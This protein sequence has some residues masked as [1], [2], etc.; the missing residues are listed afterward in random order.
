MREAG[1]FAFEN[2]HKRSKKGL[3][4]IVAL[5]ILF[6][7]VCFLLVLLSRW[8]FWLPGTNMRA[9]IKAD[10]SSVHDLDVYAT[11]LDSDRTNLPYDFYDMPICKPDPFV[12]YNL[13]IGDL[14]FGFRRYDAP[15]RFSSLNNQTIKSF[16][17]YTVSGTQYNFVRSSI[18]EG[19]RMNFLLDNLD[20]FEPRPDGLYKQ[21]FP[22]GFL[23]VTDNSNVY[24]VNN[25]FDIRVFYHILPHEGDGD[26]I[27]HIVGFEAVP[28]SVNW[29]SSNCDIH[30]VQSCGHYSLEKHGEIPYT[31]SV[32]WLPSKLSWVSRWDKYLVRL[33]DGNMTQTI[34]YSTLIVVLLGV[35]AS[36]MFRRVVKKSLLSELEMP[37]IEDRDTLDEILE[38]NGWKLIATNVYRTPRFSGLLSLFVGL[39]DM[40]LW[41]TIVLI[42]C[43]WVGLFSPARRNAVGTVLM[44]S[45]ILLW[46]RCS[47]VTSRKLREFKNKKSYRS[48]FLWV[49]IFI[50]LG[51]LAYYI[52]IWLVVQQSDTSYAMPFLA[53]IQY[54]LVFFVF[55]SLTAVIGIFMSKN[56]K[57]KPP[58]IVPDALPREIP[59]TGFPGTYSLSLIVSTLPF[60]S[61]ALGIKFVFFSITSN[62]VVYIF[63]LI[64]VI[65]L[66]S[67]IV[68]ILTSTITCYI[69]LQREDY[70][71]QWTS[72]FDSF[73]AGMY[74]FLYLLYEINSLDSS[75]VATFLMIHW[76][77]LGCLC[78]G[79]AFGVTGYYSA[80]IFVNRLYKNVKAH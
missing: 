62:H 21:G 12:S 10:N 35:V 56:S 63:G 7:L 46:V 11:I 65:F 59:R 22:I 2:R 80:R 23:G 6:V 43:A 42:A 68:C 17:N 18:I 50:P 73:F 76:G 71:W 39:G 29:T 69:R 33:T 58:L 51:L 61:T 24:Y 32:T 16:C 64:G 26:N 15:F 36:N 78:I 48:I 34:G 66:L 14:F 72:F 47:Y 57:I 49:C 75:A 67:L 28:Y 79:L 44:F 55:V 38:S 77:F 25:H 19:Y 3:F 74:C 5:G 13:S 45:V 54:G 1:T 52:Y 41:V 30:N 20:M 60:A 31:Y 27:F 53:F 8:D 70:R 37:D 9:Y 40:M 4:Y